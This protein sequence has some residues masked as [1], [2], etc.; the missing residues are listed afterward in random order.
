MFSWDALDPLPLKRS[1][2]V[3]AAFRD[4]TKPDLR[5]AARY[6]CGLRYRR[7]SDPKAP[8][9]VL[10]EKR[11]TCSTKHALLR[12][13]AIEQGFDLALILGLYEMTERNTPGIGPVLQKY[14]ISS[15]LEAHCYLRTKNGRIDLT[16]LLREESRAEPI[17]NFLHEEEISPDQITH[18][19]IS[20]HKTFL[21]RWVAGQ[22]G[23]NEFSLDEIWRIREE[24]I[25]RLSQL[26]SAIF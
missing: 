16:R 1:G 14:G 20:V 9:I 2:P 21:Q 7:N 15:L 19:K 8:L 3:A 10:L 13:L 17:A 24:C 26:E 12:R 4:L 25:A 22:L 23:L 6:V 5:S 18:Y 11:G